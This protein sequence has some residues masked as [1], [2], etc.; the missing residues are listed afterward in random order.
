MVDWRGDMAPHSSFR[1]VAM[2]R[3]VA[4]ANDSCDQSSKAL[5]A[6]ICPALRVRGIIFFPINC[7]AFAF[8]YWALLFQA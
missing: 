1:I 3:L 5:A 4:W 2:E 8:L 6:L 7:Y